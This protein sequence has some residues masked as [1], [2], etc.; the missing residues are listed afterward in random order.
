MY[1]HYYAVALMF[2][3]MYMYC[4]GINIQNIKPSVSLCLKSIINRDC[5]LSYYKSS[6]I[7]IHVQY[8]C[9]RKR[10]LGNIRSLSDLPE[11]PLRYINPTT[12]TKQ[13]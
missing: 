6:L 1:F 4:G 8:M 9:S 10:K 11:D 7:N 5:P 2:M 3:K 13:D 12:S